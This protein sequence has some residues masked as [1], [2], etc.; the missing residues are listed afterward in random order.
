MIEHGEESSD[1]NNGGKDLK[2]ERKAEA[3][4]LFGKTD[5]TKDEFRAG[6]GVAK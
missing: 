3:G 4:K 1:K 5:V 2:G 6:V